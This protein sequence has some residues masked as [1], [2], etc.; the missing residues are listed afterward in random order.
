MAAR[1]FSFCASPFGTVFPHLYAPLTVS[2]VLGLSS[3][4]TCSQV[5]AGPLSAPLIPLSW[6]FARYKFISY[7]HLI[8]IRTSSSHNRHTVCSICLTDDHIK[9]LSIINSCQQAAHPWDCHYNVGQQCY[10]NYT[11]IYT[12]LYLYD[13]CSTSLPTG[14]LLTCIVSSMS[15]QRNSSLFSS[16]RATPTRKISS[17]P[18]N[19][20]MT[21]KNPTFTF[22]S[23]TTTWPNL[24]KFHAK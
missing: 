17:I 20:H 19:Q 5:I 24:L 18:C 7:L 11:G 9:Q 16:R 14:K 10:G 2:L 8:S 6:F 15:R 21:T 3:R 12:D 1:R 4:L 23:L 13:Y 22:V